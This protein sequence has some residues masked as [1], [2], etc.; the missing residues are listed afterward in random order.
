L[1]APSG[2]KG[3]GQVQRWRCI[4]CGEVRT[5]RTHPGPKAGNDGLAV[6]GGVVVAGIVLAVLCFGAH[7]PSLW[8]GLAWAGMAGL[9]AWYALLLG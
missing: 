2:L 8:G 6:G 7:M 3:A 4:R 5:T 9:I 1:A